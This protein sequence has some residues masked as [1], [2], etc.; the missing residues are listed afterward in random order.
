MPRL[1]WVMRLPRGL[2]EQPAWVFIGL[3]V[4]LSG[5]SYLTG[6][7]DSSVSRAIGET[8]LRVWGG[9]LAFSGFSVLWSTLVADPV[10]EKLALRIMSLSM[11]V[12]GGWVVTI[13][14]IRRAVMTLAL[15]LILSGL[16]EIRVGVLRALLKAA[17][18]KRRHPWL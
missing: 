1:P 7:A 15:T 14:D 8:G 2:R 4:G 9:F 16:A 10:L 11:L 5:V 3:L 12:Y 17:P 13:I 6:V 18:P